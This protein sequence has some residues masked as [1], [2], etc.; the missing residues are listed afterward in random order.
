MIVSIQPTEDGGLSATQ[1]QF[2]P[3]VYFD[4][5]AMRAIAERPEVASRFV[6]AMRGKQASLLISSMTLYEF[7]LLSDERHARAADAL[8]E[9][10]FRN[11]Y[12]IQCEASL[13]L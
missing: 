7:S 1:R 12:F 6:A 8:L 13:S 3:A 11:L 10:L 9:Q 5:C 4:M 2:T